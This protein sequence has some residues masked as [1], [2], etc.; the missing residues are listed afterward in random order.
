MNIFSQD[1]ALVTRVERHSVV[2]IKK[3]NF[4][5][6]VKQARGGFADKPLAD[7]FAIDIWRMQAGWQWFV[8]AE[9]RQTLLAPLGQPI[10]ERPCEE[11]QSIYQ[12]PIYSPELDG[13]A[14]LVLDTKPATQSFNLIRRTFEGTPE[15]YRGMIPVVYCTDRH[16]TDDGWIAELT[17]E[18]WIER[19][20]IFGQRLI[21]VPEPTSQHER[22]IVG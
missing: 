10:A 17:V 15:Y 5:Y 3:G 2:T 14:D 19:T 20:G 6:P 8:K 16:E 21:A 18:D 22:V 7:P 1:L 11:A 12:V 9:G 13:R 4:V